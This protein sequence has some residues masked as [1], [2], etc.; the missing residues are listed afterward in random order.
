MHTY[1]GDVRT[2]TEGAEFVLEMTGTE[3]AA[4]ISNTY[5]SKQFY[6]KVDDGEYELK[7]ISNHNPTII[8]SGATSGKHTVYIKPAITSD[9]TRRMA[10]TAF[11]TRDAAYQTCKYVHYGDTNADG[12][13]NLKDLVNMKKKMADLEV[14]C[15]PVDIDKDGKMASGDLIKLR[16]HLFGDDIIAWEDAE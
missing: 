3:L 12:V 2:S 9:T 4:H 8:F 15:P 6:V 14:Y 7:D 10:F 1:D 16:K 13:I 11:F 5:T